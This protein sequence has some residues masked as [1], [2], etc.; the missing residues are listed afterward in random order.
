L[1]HL[2]LLTIV[3]STFALGLAIQA[4][5]LR[6]LRGVPAILPAPAGDGLLHF[7]GAIIPYQNIAIIA[8]TLVLVGA[9]M[10]LMQR[11]AI[12]R[13]IR[14]LAADR[15]AAML[16]G[17]RVERLSMAMFGLSAAL[18]ALA[19]LMVAP[20][21]SLSPTLGFGLL[22]NAFPAIFIGGFDRIDITLAA[23]IVIGVLQALYNINP[24]FIL[25]VAMVLRPQGVW[26]AASDR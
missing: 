17:V 18:A 5:I 15:E 26:P 6:W 14:A 4:V 19:G 2:P 13:Q 12:G 21:I 7:H 24:F 1:R 11:T 16:Q 23:A 22:I 25:L 20:T 3:I 10:V 8:V 9:L